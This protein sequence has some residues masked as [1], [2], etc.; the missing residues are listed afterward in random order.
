MQPEIRPVVVVAG[1]A[2]T[3]HEYLEKQRELFGPFESRVEFRYLTD[4]PLI[5]ILTI[6]SSLPSDTVLIESALPAIP[7]DRP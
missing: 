3:D 2:T 1:S 6:V 4:L 7:V 5:D